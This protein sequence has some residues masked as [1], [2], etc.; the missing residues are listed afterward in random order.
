M[1]FIVFFFHFLLDRGQRN[2]IDNDEFC[3]T[4]RESA[5]V[6]TVVLLFE[7]DAKPYNTSDKKALFF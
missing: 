1:D 4:I 3:E 7:G 2:N 5:I 6:T